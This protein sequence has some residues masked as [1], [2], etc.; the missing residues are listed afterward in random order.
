MTKSYSPS[1][2]APTLASSVPSLAA[3]ETDRSPV[4]RGWREVSAEL[5]TAVCGLF[6]RAGALPPADVI[7]LLA[8]LRALRG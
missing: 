5:E 7:R 4:T 3:P 1:V 2:Y 6:D 8:E